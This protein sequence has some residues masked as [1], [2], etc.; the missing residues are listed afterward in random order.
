MFWLLDESMIDHDLDLI[1]HDDRQIM[2]DPGSDDHLKSDHR[3]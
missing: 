3:D 1:N 2:I